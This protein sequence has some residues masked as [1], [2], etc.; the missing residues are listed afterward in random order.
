MKRL[1]GLNRSVLTPL[2]LLLIAAGGYG[3][4]RGAE[5]FGERSASAPLLEDD[6]RRFVRDNAWWFWT[7]VAVA[8]ALVALLAWRW[9]RV[10]LLPTPSLDELPVGSRR[11][12]RTT[13]SSGAVS[14]ALRRELEAHRD[15]SSARARVVGDA[16]KPTLDLRASVVDGGDHEAVRQWVEDEVLPRAREALEAPEMTATLRLRLGDAAQRVVA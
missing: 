9:L 14:D 1:D 16:D 15:V 10:Q 13:L 5:V 3:L 12:G 7:A 2:A 11:Q 4:L 8:A 6:L